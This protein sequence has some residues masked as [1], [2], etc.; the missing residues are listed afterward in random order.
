MGVKKGA[1]GQPGQPLA[2]SVPIFSRLFQI[3]CLSPYTYRSNQLLE[4][5]FVDRRME[6]KEVKLNN[7]KMAS[8]NEYD[9]NV[10][11]IAKLKQRLEKAGQDV[12]ETN[13]KLKDLWQ[14]N[15]C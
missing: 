11:A 15:E 10:N 4:E 6:E 5:A 12:M 3:T 13:E 14:V 8:Q 9:R 1:E 7:V 2:R